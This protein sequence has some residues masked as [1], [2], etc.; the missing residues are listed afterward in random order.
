MRHTNKKHTPQFSSSPPAAQDHFLSR[1]ARQCWLDGDAAGL[2]K[3]VIEEIDSKVASGL[4]RSFADWRLVVRH[5]ADPGVL[6]EEGAELEAPLAEEEAP[7]HEEADTELCAADDHD[8]ANMFTEAV[9]AVAPLEVTAL[10]GD[11]E[12]AVVAASQA[13]KRLD[14][15]K[16][17]RAEALGAKVP[18]AFFHYDRE[19]SQMERGLRAKTPAEKASAAILRR[20]VEKAQEDEA[21][22]LRAKR[23]KNRKLAAQQRQL[24]AETARARQTAALKKATAVAAAKAQKAK[25]VALQAKLDALPKTILAK[26]C[27]LGAKGFV[28]RRDCL[29]RVRLRCPPLPVA[30]EAKWGH[31]RDAFARFFPHTLPH[32]NVGGAFIQ[33][34]N[35]L[36]KA[37]GE[38]YKGG[39]LYSKAGS[40]GNARAFEAFVRGMEKAIPKSS[41]VTL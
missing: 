8:V 39:S 21:A 38:H 36:L 9:P 7:W 29:E 13:S 37:L 33:Q 22:K 17:L 18:A 20:A 28:A 27:G 4:L 6:R 19:V 35:T 5:P 25:A 26:D 31:V 12:E 10:P 2:R 41:G 30:T 14:T 1:V 23:A 32:T 34:I 11:A 16:R 24:K 3:E 15:L 40:G